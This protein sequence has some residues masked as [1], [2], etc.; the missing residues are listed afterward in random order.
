MFA[1]VWLDAY[2]YVTACNL[3]WI[4]SRKRVRAYMCLLDLHRLNLTNFYLIYCSGA[5]R[6]AYWTAHTLE[7]YGS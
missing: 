1:Q 3:S 5:W 7:R 2:A 6:L 4:T